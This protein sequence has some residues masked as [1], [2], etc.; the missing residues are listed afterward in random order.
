[1]HI[2]ITG[3]S[4]FI[5]RALAAHLEARGNTVLRIGRALPPGPGTLSVADLATLGDHPEFL[6]GCDALVHLAG[7]AHVTDPGLQATLPYHAVNAL[8]TGAVAAAARAA[9]LRRVVYVST[10]GVL[11]NASGPAALT[12]ASPERPYD[13]YT[14]SKLDGEALLKRALDGGATE[15]CIVRPPMVVGP[16]APG[17]L[18]RLLRLMGSGWLLPLASIR[19]RR[20]YVGLDNLAEFIAVC[21]EHPGAAGQTFVVADEPSVSTPEFIRLISSAMGR[22]ARLMPCPPGLLAAGL[23][24]LGREGDWRR[25][26]GSFALDASH[27]GR[28]LGWRPPLSLLQSLQR[29]VAPPPG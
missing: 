20:S 23:K 17:N 11:G 29:A 13:A 2:A 19:N 4:G 16:G 9:G 7:L 6:E 27:A 24:A 1:M 14:R 18:G 5:A 21:L 15:W 26:S 8:G 10:A 3:A 28:Q 22:R 25:L 12:E